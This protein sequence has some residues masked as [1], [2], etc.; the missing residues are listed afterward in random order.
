MKIP[1]IL[2]CLLAAA[3]TAM[4]QDDNSERKAPPTADELIAKLDKDNDGKISKAEFDGPSEHF[5]MMDKDE[6]GYISKEEV[7]SGP[8][9]RKER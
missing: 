7:P 9:P 8:P 6:D 2:V 5:T 3:G 1:L 4:A